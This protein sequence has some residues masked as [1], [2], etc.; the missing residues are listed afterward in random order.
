MS[1]TSTMAKPKK[2]EGQNK[3]EETT[4]SKNDTHVDVGHPLVNLSCHKVA[5]PASMLEVFDA[6]H[7]SNGWEGLPTGMN[8]QRHKLRA[9][10]CRRCV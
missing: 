8:T 1:H 7:D 10:S 3:Q 2:E 9:A 6:E 4:G 5:N